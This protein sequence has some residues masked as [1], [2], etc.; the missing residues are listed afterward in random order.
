MRIACFS[1]VNPRPSGISDYTEALLPHL[2]KRVDEIDLFVED[3]Q[4]SARLQAPNIRVRSWREFEPDHRAG[5]FYTVLYHIGNNPFHV[6]IYDLALRIPGVVVLHEFNLHYL[7]AHATI[8]RGDW[9]AYFRELGHNAGPAAMQRARRAQQGVGQLDYD[10]VPMNRT[11]LERS[12][13][14]IVHSDYMVSLLRAAGAHLPVRRI[15]H[16]VGLQETDHV[17]GRR[18][19][20]ERAGW[21]LDDSTPVFGVFG[22][23]KPYKRIRE[24]LRAFARLRVENPA[25]KMVLVGEEHPHYPLRPLISELDLGDSVV[26]LGHLPLGQFTAC[27]SG[28][29]YCI[30]LRRPTAGE[31]SGSVM[32]SLALGKPTLVSEIGSFLE[33]PDDAVFKIPVDDKEE[34]WLLEYIKLLVAE[35]ELAVAVGANGQAY[36]RQNCLWPQVADQYVQ[37]LMECAQ[38]QPVSAFPSATVLEPQNGKAAQVAPRED[39]IREYIVGFSHSSR[40][41]EDYAQDHLS[42]LEKTVLMTPQGTSADRLLEL[43]CYLQITPALS[44][45]L[46]YGEIRGAYYGKLGEQ[47]NQSATSVTGEIF[48]CRVDLFDAERDRFPYPDGYFQTVLCCE[49]IEHLTSDPMHMMAEINRIVALGG[50]LLLSTPNIV[51]F[52]SAYAV[53]H[54][55]HPGLFPAYIKPSSDGTVDPRHSREYAPREVS[56]L[57]EA[58]GFQVEKLETGNYSRKERDI[59]WVQEFLE[60]NQLATGLR[61]EVIYCLARKVG[62][63]RDRWPKELYYP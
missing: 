34:Q 23:L 61:G 9:E 42:R 47:V 1:P 25:V 43:G 46:G 39:E 28:V 59:R 33:L 18:A 13:A 24:S 7:V 57:A 29:D 19:L 50:H 63:V 12:R 48:T 31:T 3:Y 62:P 2:A 36:V 54:G 17:A 22:F 21:S 56:L 37:F 5:R 60:T 8:G 55:Y 30:S 11:L 32:R 26:I 52:R 45:Y 38:A 4:P 41:M 40:L 49:L 6:Y 35:P 44:R 16:G 27:M 58:S 14:A 10:S 51:S 53:L 15:P 20:A